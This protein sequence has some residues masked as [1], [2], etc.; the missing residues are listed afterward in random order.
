MQP[1]IGWMAVAVAVAVAVPIISGM[2]I[3][4]DWRL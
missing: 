2:D 1:T 3:V 4:K